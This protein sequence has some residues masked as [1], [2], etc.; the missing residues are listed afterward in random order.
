MNRQRQSPGI[1]HQ[2]AGYT[3]T[4]KPSPGTPLEVTRRQ[5]T[6]NEYVYAGVCVAENRQAYPWHPSWVTRVCV[7]VYW[8]VFPWDY[9][10]EGRLYATRKTSLPL[11]NI[12]CIHLLR[13]MQEQCTNLSSVGVLSLLVNVSVC[14]LRLHCH[15]W[16]RHRL[17]YSY[18]WEWACVCVS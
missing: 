17:E 18:Q 8:Q 2:A 14:A 15:W 11:A 1:V 9:S 10:P 16:W 7:C 13:T 4:D 3:K 12:L 5:T 6:L